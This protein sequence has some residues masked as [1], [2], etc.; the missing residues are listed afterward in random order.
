[1]QCSCCGGVCVCYSSVYLEVEVCNVLAVEVC[2][3][4]KDLFD[5]S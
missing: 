3:A 1:M 4:I 5:E 2:H